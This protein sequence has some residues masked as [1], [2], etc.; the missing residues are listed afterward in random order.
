MLEASVESF[1]GDVSKLTAIIHENL[2]GLDA[3]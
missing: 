2:S 1:Q 3:P